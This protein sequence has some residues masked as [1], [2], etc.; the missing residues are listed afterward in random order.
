MTRVRGAHKNKIGRGVL[1]G[2]LMLGL[3]ACASAKDA[4]PPD[5]NLSCTLRHGG[6]RV[7]SLKRL[8]QPVRAALKKLA[9]DMADRGE[10]FNAGD[11]VSKPAPF[12]RFIRGGIADGHW[13]VWYEHGGIAYWHHVVI[14]AADPY[15]TP[16]FNGRST[17]ADLCAMTDGMLDGPIREHQ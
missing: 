11:V 1:A 7:D 10:F 2:L 15:A 13:Y 9:G 14:F 16:L 17:I 6:A 5:P 4:A 12:N 8:P 3:T